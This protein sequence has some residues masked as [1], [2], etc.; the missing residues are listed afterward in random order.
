MWIE[1]RATIHAS[2]WSRPGMI[3]AYW[4]EWLTTAHW[5]SNSSGI[6]GMLLM[7][8]VWV[9]GLYLPQFIDSLAHHVRCSQAV[10]CCGHL[11]HCGVCTIWDHYIG[12]VEGVTERMRTMTYLLSCPGNSVSR[13]LVP[14]RVQQRGRRLNPTRGISFFFE[15]RLSG[16]VR[17]VCNL[18]CL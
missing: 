1:W 8:H 7:T 4:I 18:H 15:E 16:V 17:I 11:P 10:S 5:F 2:L 3:G 13:A 9:E 6:E 12:R 14:Y